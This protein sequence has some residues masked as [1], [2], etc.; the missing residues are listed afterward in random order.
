MRTLTIICVLLLCA[1]SQ[2]RTVKECYCYAETVVELVSA[3]PERD[4]CVDEA[5]TNLIE[6]SY[7]TMESVFACEV[8]SN[9]CGYG[10]T[11][12]ERQQAFDEYLLAFSVTNHALLA[13]RD[14][15]TAALALLCCREKRYTNSLAAAKN[16]LKNPSSPYGR[17]AIGLLLDMHR[18]TCDMNQIVLSV[19]TNRHATTGYNR[20]AT[21]SAYVNSLARSED[22]SPS[23]K[24]NAA[25]A[26]F[27]NR[28]LIEDRISVDRLMLM[29][30]D[31][32]VGSSN[33][34]LFANDVL[35]SGDATETERVY[36]ASVTNAIGPVVH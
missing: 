24:T 2:G 13:A 1:T 18:P 21:M 19:V 22:L 29:A 33:R 26:F 15:S 35:S 31:D 23:V 30:Y 11:E 8:S 17:Y 25:N 6:I 12:K 9:S 32:Y 20:C 14:A 36:F 7:P 34:V 16:I 10:W 5:S 4:D 28:D 3:S 27:D